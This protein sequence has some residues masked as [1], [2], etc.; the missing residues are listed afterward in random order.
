MSDRSVA[1]ATPPVRGERGTA[2]LRP[3]TEVEA[4][5]RRLPVCALIP[6]YN[7]AHMLERALQSVWAQRPMLP[8]EVMVVDD[9]SSDETAAVAARLG[10]KVIQ[11]PENRGLATARNTGL[12]ATSCPWVALLDSDDEWLPHHLATLWELHGE[13][14]LVAGSSLRIGSDP[15]AYRYHGPLMR[16]PLVLRSGRPLIYPGNLIPV[17]AS[18]VKRDAAL[19]AGGFQARRGVVEDLDLWLRMLERGTAICSPRVSAVYHLHNDQM[20]V[21]QRRDMQLAHLEAADAYRQRNGLSRAP[22]KRWE[23]VA[24]WDNLR[25]AWTDAEKRTAARWGRYIASNPHRVAGL[26]GIL[27]WRYFIRRRSAALRA[28]GVGIPPSAATHSPHS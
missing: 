16:R 20:S 4:I 12:E 26:A 24:A 23:A 15:P 21:A 3:L 11:H 1:A 13:H 5:P 28:A 19:A 2:R 14:V 22:L 9:G 18:M 8:A 10:A 25:L 6:A 17:S 27:V 7:R